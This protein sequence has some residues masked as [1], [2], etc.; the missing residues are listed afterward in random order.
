MYK[1]QVKYFVRYYQERVFTNATIGNLQVSNCIFSNVDN[2]EKGKI[3]M[4]KDIANINIKNSVFEKSINTQH[5]IHL[6]GPKNKITNCLVSGTGKIKT[7][8]GALQKRIFF[9]NPKWENSKE[10]IPSEK[11]ILLKENNKSETIGLIR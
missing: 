1:R 11:S 6:S 9:K 8:K 4:V 2:R 5:I 10:F 7:D 3:I